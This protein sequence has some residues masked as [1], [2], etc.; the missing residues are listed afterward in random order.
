MKQYLLSVY[1][2]DREPPP[3]PT[4]AVIV[5]AAAFTSGPALSTSC[6]GNPLPTLVKSIAALLVRR[7][8]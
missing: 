3:A 6:E 8:L 4:F 5:P 1:Q 2:P 7:S